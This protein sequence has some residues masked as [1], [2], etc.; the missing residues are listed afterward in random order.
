M[1]KADRNDRIQSARSWLFTPGTKQGA[2]GKAADVGADAVI[3]DLEDSVALADK[4]GARTAVL[5]HL[6]Q[7]G[8]DILRAVRI[9]ATGTLA[10]LQ[11]LLTLV[12]AKTLADAVV[13]PKVE[14]GG[15]LDVVTDLLDAVGSTL[16]IL[17]IIESARGVR[18]LAAILDQQP[19]VASIVVGAADL[20]ADMGGSPTW[21]ALAPAR[22][23]ILTA[24]S[25][26]RIPVIDSP[27]FDPADSA[28]LKTE[29]QRAAEMGFTAKAAIHPDQVATINASWTPTTADIAWAKQVVSVNQ[30]GV[31][32][33]DGAMVDR[34]VARR[35][36]RILQ[37][38]HRE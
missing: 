11:D 30:A 4:D 7:P 37:R 33:V 14:S 36:R 21:E 26:A 1:T 17:P 27:F 31:G 18:D 3:L 9:N 2:F 10:G 38:E 8:A 32:T 12:H 34:A 5:N 29:T 28:G 15:L 19:R 24:A 25:A 20:A 16:S 13:L 23:A 35:A 6:A 22:G